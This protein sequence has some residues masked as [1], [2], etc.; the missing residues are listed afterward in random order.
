MA[1][2]ITLI[3][4]GIQVWRFQTRQPISWTD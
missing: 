2:S 3:I 1:I 4:T